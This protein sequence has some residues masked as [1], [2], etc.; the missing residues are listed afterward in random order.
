MDKEHVRYD[1]MNATYDDISGHTLWR[2]ASTVCASV[3]VLDKDATVA[4][5]RPRLLLLGV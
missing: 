4:I 2:A 5:C 1:W 3:F